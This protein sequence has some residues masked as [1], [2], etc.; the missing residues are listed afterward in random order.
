MK[1][2]QPGLR[3]PAGP[4]G[5][6]RHRPAMDTTDFHVEVIDLLGNRVS[7]EAGIAFL[8]ALVS[9]LRKAPVAP[10][11]RHPRRPEHPRQHQVR[12][13]PGRAA[14]GRHGQRGSPG[15]DP[16]GEQ[17]ELPGGVRGHRRES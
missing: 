14:P 7:C 1:E 15:L 12:A 9:A 11:L 4:Q 13:L 17:A 5:Q 6:D 8:V 3:L 16:A 2:S 10:G